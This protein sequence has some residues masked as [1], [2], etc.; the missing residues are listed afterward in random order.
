[1]FSRSFPVSIP[2]DYPT[3]IWN[4]NRTFIFR[5]VIQKST[6]GQI[7]TRSAQSEWLY[8]AHVGCCHPSVSLRRVRLQSPMQFTAVVSNL[9]PCEN[10]P[11]VCG[12]NQRA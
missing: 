4:K 2:K 12:Y 5:S 10:L 6:V 7:K 1:M 9:C 8:Q 3:F 11:L